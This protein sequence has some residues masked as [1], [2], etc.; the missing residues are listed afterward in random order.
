VL[1]D[2]SSSKK[3]TR[4]HHNSELPSHETNVEILD[5][6]IRETRQKQWGQ[7]KENVPQHPARSKHNQ[8]KKRIT[9]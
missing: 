8:H 1:R 9:R 7:H 5:T 3:E 6:G 4:K 2:K